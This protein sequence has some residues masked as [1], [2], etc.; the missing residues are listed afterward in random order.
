M[1]GKKIAVKIVN[2][3][4]LNESVLQKVGELIWLREGPSFVREKSF[5]NV[6]KG[7]EGNCYN[8]AD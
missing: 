4:K 2:K 7:G 6:S 1:T 8:E 3:E 5:V